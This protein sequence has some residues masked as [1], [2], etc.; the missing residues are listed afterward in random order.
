MRE[1]GWLIRAALQSAFALGAG[2]GCAATV[3]PKDGGASV[4]RAAD[5]GAPGV[6]AGRA[7]RVLTKDAGHATVPDAATAL[8]PR[9]GKWP[10]AGALCDAAVD[11]G[12]AAEATGEPSQPYRCTPPEFGRCPSE[13]APFDS[14]AECLAT[15]GPA[16]DAHASQCQDRGTLPLACGPEGEAVH[17]QLDAE[18]PV[19]RLALSHAWLTRVTGFTESVS[20]YFTAAG[21]ARFDSR[22]LVQLWLPAWGMDADLVGAHVGR[23]TLQ[24]CPGAFELPVAVDIV[25]S[26]LSQPVL[27]LSGHVESL[28]EDVKL[29]ADFDFMS[30]CVTDVDL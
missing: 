7:A 20:I 27:R 29:S 30:V 18:T 15:C 16:F 8:D 6:D 22:P 2:S 10:A 26:T 14:L 28:S 17:A 3:Q 13:P 12:Y 1:L 19:G 4:H 9:C 24:L 21:E 5:A 25:E 23:G 11:F